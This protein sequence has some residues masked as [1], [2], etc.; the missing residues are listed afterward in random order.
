MLW[1][2]EGCAWVLV[3]SGVENEIYLCV[4]SFV[5]GKVYGQ[6]INTHPRFVANS[7]RPYSPSYIVDLVLTF[8]DFTILLEDYTSIS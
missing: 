8:H 2:D 4:G 1:G 5:C 3:S 6:G 7:V